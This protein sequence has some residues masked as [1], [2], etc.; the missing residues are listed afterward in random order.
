MQYVKRNA[1]A[2]TGSTTAGALMK[3]LVAAAVLDGASAD[4]QHR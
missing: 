1:G 2:H 4:L 3:A